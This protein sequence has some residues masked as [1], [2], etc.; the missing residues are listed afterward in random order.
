MLLA[1]LLVA[2]TTWPSC[3]SSPDEAVVL[4]RGAVVERGPTAR[5]LDNPEHP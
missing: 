5:V 2:T 3:A 1:I 4:Q